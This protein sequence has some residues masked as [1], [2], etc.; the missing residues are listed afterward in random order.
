MLGKPVRAVETSATGGAYI[1]LS[2]RGLLLRYKL[3]GGDHPM[4]TLIGTS[5][6]GVKA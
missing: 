5:V 6:I 4:G 3:R 2:S 1:G